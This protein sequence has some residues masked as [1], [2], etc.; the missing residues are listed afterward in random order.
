MSL[1]EYCGCNN[2]VFAD[3]VFSQLEISDWGINATFENVA[4]REVNFSN[5]IFQ[6]TVFS[7]CSM[8]DVRFDSVQFIDTVWN[9]SSLSG[10]RINSS[11]FCGYETHNFTSLEEITATTATLL[12]ETTFPQLLDR[13]ENASCSRETAPVINCDKEDHDTRVY[14]DNFFISASALPGNIIAGIAVYFFRRNYWM[15]EYMYILVGYMHVRVSSPF[16]KG[17]EYVVSGMGI[18][19]ACARP[20]NWSTV[21]RLSNSSQSGH[22]T[23]MYYPIELRC[24]NIIPSLKAI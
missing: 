6:S 20:R 21:T 4:F 10:I 22:K 9:S 7:G 19:L 1:Q 2:T 8:E 15:S 16:P 3:V 13:A 14:K 17:L 18:L 12:N 23:R 24:V 5:V 11:E